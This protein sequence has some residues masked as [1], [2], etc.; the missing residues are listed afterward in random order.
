MKT[1]YYYLIFPLLLCLSQMLHAQ[2]KPVKPIEPNEKLN[3]GASV[4]KQLVY[5]DAGGE[6]GEL[7][8]F[9]NHG[10]SVVQFQLFRLFLQPGMG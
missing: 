9:L 5:H 6:Y 1:R 10:T 4:T 8:P 3:A 2:D 7:L